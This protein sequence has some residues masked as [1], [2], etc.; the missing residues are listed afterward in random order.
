MTI[1]K[2]DLDAQAQQKAIIDYWNKG[3][4]RQSIPPVQVQADETYGVAHI[5]LVRPLSD[6]ERMQLNKAIVELSD[7]IEEIELV[8]GVTVPAEIDGRN[9]KYQIN[10]HLRTEPQATEDQPPE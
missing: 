8:A 10:T 5:K 6:L 1:W 4:G 3:G 7:L 9:W 2:E